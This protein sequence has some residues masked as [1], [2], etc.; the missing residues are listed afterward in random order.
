M[1][2]AIRSGLV[3]L[4]IGIGVGAAWVGPAQA[5]D[6]SPPAWKKWMK[7]NVVPA[8]AA[9]DFKKLEVLLGKIAA[10]N[11]D[12]KA[13]PKW[14]EFCDQGIAASKKGDKDAL[15]K[16]CTACHNAYR[17]VFREKYRDAPP[18]K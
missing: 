1:T 6:D 4:A 9:G 11:P 13:F 5:G 8:K 3:A 7:E 15:N 16:S 18:P 17:K 10:A 14:Q 12:D 2:K